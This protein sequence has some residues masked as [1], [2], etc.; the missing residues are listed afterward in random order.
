MNGV[1]G[2][3][4]LSLVQPSVLSNPTLAS[5]RSDIPNS[6]MSSKPHELD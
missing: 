3:L 6:D 4:S 1:R 2:A 5:C